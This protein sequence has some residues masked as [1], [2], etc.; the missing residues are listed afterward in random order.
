MET[1]TKYQSEKFERIWVFEWLVN[2]GV[3]YV[4]EVNY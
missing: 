2:S 1:S 3:N 4:R